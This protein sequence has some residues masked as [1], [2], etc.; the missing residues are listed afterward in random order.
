MDALQVMPFMAMHE[1]TMV[2]N[3]GVWWHL[4]CFSIS[5][6]FPNMDDA[7]AKRKA[8]LYGPPAPRP[9][10]RP[11]YMHPYVFQRVALSSLCLSRHVLH[12]QACC[13]NCNAA[14]EAIQ[15][16]VLL[17]NDSNAH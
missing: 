7:D 17:Q 11:G 16:V 13:S 15:H 14:T 6:I 5:Q 1:L 10:Y 4:N 8:G 3:H 9:L 2:A 12:M